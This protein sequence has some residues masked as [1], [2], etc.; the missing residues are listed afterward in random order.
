MNAQD[1]TL[2]QD[3]HASYSLEDQR[4][5]VSLPRKGNIT[6]LSNQHNAVKLFQKL[7][8]IL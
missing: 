3:F 1:T 4:S 5:V 8:Q 2:L 6:L 7:E